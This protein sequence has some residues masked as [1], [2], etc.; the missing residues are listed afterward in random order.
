MNLFETIKTQQVEAR[1]ARETI[2]A[3]LLTTL[4]GEISTQVAGTSQHPSDDVS[5]AVIKKFIKN[6]NETLR[7]KDNEISKQELEILESFL[8]KQ[9]TDVELKALV[10]VYVLVGKKEGKQGGAL[11]GFVMKEMKEG[12]PDRYDASKVKALV[13]N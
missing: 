6:T 11:V 5:I 3:T 13:L 4:L 9:L 1:K 12:Y 7:L 10:D 8:P 2:K